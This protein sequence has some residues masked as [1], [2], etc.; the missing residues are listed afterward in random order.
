[1]SSFTA[2]GQKVFLKAGS[3]RNDGAAST[4]PTND[5]RIMAVRMFDAMRKL[6]RDGWLARPPNPDG[7]IFQIQNRAN[8]QHAPVF[9]KRWRGG[10]VR[11]ARLAR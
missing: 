1:V 7:A 6:V 3:Q 5:E 4:T 2:S 8:P 11:L 9:T 10:L